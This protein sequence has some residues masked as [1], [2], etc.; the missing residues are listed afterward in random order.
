[1]VIS[2]SDNFFLCHSVTLSLCHSVTYS[3]S[4]FLTLSAIVSFNNGLIRQDSELSPYGQVI[5]RKQLVHE[6]ADHIFFRIDIKNG[7]ENTA[8]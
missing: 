5:L 2:G 8:P 6:Y 7:V 1:M 4:H 3:L